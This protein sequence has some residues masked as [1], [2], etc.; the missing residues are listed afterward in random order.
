MKKPSLA[1]AVIIIILFLHA[2]N[3]NSFSQGNQTGPLLFIGGGALPESMYGEFIKLTD[4]DAKLIV[5]PT[6]SGGDI[7]V[8]EIIEKWHSRGFKTVEVLHTRDRNIS[9]SPEFSET[10]KSARTVWISG[11][12]QQRI[13]DAYLGTPVENELYKLIDR[14]GLIGGSSAG[15]AIQTRLMI[16]G[17]DTLPEISRGFDL[18]KGAIVDQHFLKRNRLSRLISAVRFYPDLIGYGIDEGSAI[19]CYDNEYRII[20][21][22]YVLRVQIK[23]G[24]I[25]MDA[26]KDGDIIPIDYN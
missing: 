15:A 2:C 14:G 19:V 17:G 5:I 10:L 4:P 26:F 23:N 13:A 16:R 25:E 9:M 22:S 18:M 8:D 6:A 20:G 3:D 24:V 11:G 21:E 12:S 1:L 7:N